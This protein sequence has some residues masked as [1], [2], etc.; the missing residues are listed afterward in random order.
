MGGEHKIGWIG[1]YQVDKFSY[2]QHSM[3]QVATF[4]DAHTHPLL[5]LRNFRLCFTAGGCR[6]RRKPPFNQAKKVWVSPECGCQQVLQLHSGAVEVSPSLGVS[7]LRYPSFQLLMQ[8][9]GEI[10]TLMYLIL[11]SQGKDLPQITIE[12]RVLAR[13][14]L[15]SWYTDWIW[16]LQCQLCF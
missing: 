13:I 11:S 10:G 8:W 4:P 16:I 5:K 3:A 14:F 2:L 15:S 6:V 1:R 7:G 9:L 12:L